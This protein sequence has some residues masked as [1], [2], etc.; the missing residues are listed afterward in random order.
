MGRD[1]MVLTIAVKIGVLGP[2]DPFRLIL[3][4]RRRKL[5]GGPRKSA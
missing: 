5:I 1:V 2:P 4:T 3:R